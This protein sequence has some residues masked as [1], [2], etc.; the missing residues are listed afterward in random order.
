MFWE[1]ADR[2][3][4]DYAIY[5]DVVFDKGL[6]STFIMKLIFASPFKTRVV[7]EIANMLVWPIT[8]LNRDLLM[9]GVCRSVTHIFSG[10]GQTKVCEDLF[11]NMRERETHDSNNGVRAIEAYYA[12][13]P[14]MGIIS[15][16]KRDE[17]DITEEEPAENVTARSVFTSKT[18]NCTL[19]DAHEIC[20]KAT[21]PTLSPST[22]KSLATNMALLRHANDAD[23][24][25]T[26]NKCWQCERLQLRTVIFH[27]PTKKYFIVLG[28]LCYQVALV[29]AVGDV[30]VGKTNHRAFLLGNGKVL[31]SRPT[32]LPI[33]DIE[34]YEIV[35]STPVCPL[36]Y[37]LALN[38]RFPKHRMGVVLLQ[39]DDSCAVLLYAARNAFFTMQLPQL[40]II[41]NE[42][43]IDTPAVTLCA[44]LTAVIRHMWKKYLKVEI[45]DQ[46][47][48]TILALRHLE[49]DS[50]IPKVC[51][52]DLLVTLLEK[53]DIAA[54]QENA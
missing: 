22:S 44:T 13:M 35:P 45:S 41:V 36:H 15:A 42:H 26:V 31:N 11:K 37:F 3:V 24:W 8:G 39:H 16:H 20:N 30:A 6:K 28:P 18:H 4:K 48:L 12:A 52:D 33:L 38:K 21:W 19:D 54:F 7:R 10:W 2:L 27:I 14:S 46:E 32:M 34:E 23:A 29:W 5:L 50:D 1:G 49:E 53:E 17:L 43:D 9:V 51:D 25:T 40:K 47:L